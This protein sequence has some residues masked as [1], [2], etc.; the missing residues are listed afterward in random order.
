MKQEKSY[1]EKVTDIKKYLKQKE[2]EVANNRVKKSSRV[3]SEKKYDT[4]I[5]KF[6]DIEDNKNIKETEKIES[7]DNKENKIKKVSKTKKEI[8]KQENNQKMSKLAIT[9]L[10]LLLITPIC[11]TFAVISYKSNYLIREPFNY[12]L[13]AVSGI[14]LI[15]ITCFSLLIVFNFKTIFKTKYLIA[16]LITIIID[17]VFLIICLKVKIWLE[18]DFVIVHKKLLFFGFI[19]VILLLGL[20]LLIRKIMS[21]RL[22]SSI[23]RIILTIFMTFYILGF[24]DLLIVLYV[25]KDFKEWLITTAMKT[26]EHQYFC[27]WFYSDTEI[28]YILS[29]NYVLESG[30]STDPNLIKKAEE[31]EEIIVYENEYEEAVLKKNKKDDLYKIIELNVNGC[32]GYLAVI[33]DP[34]TVRVAVTDH[35][36]K[37]GQYVTTMAKNS[38]AVL[39]TNGGGFYDPGYTS[40][41]GSPTG[42]TIV[43]GKIVTNGEYGTNVKTGGIIGLDEDGVLYLLKNTTAQQA[44]D[45]GIKYAVS[46]GPFLIVNGKPSFIK[47]NGGWGYAARTAIGQREDGIILL[48][49]V[50]SNS[51]RTKGADMVDLTEIM[52]NYGAINAANLDGGTSTVMVMPK[53]TA[54]KYN[55]DCKDDY[56]LIN[57][58][59]DGALRHQTRAIADAIVVVPNE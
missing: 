22:K 31:R 26:M 57:D 36:G 5:L 50:D 30:D 56:C 13:Y 47:G 17:L 59:I 1:E 41:G 54:L 21:K 39:P 33:Y 8:K 12:L 25:P 9:L 38:G 37:Y 4:K 23:R 24:A 51:T 52:Q 44:I 29:Q 2:E 15:G 48:L 10:I 42:I 20:I 58:P 55:P 34:K 46:W 19:V 14:L 28:E 16:S 35:V 32:K 45:M 43:D 27:K 3:S 49:T 6:D 7:K 18:L 11:M 53:E 40:A